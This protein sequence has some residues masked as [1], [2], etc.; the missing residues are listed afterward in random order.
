MPSKNRQNTDLSLLSLIVQQCVKGGDETF[1]LVL[2]PTS[3]FVLDFPLVSAFC[4]SVMRFVIR[5]LRD[6]PNVTSGNIG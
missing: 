6:R 2:S 1:A 5:G 4:S 3:F